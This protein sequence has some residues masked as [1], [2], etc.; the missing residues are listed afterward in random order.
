MADRYIDPD[1][2]RARAQ[3][4][5]GH[6]KDVATNHKRVYPKS[7]D[8]V[9]VFSGPGDYFRPLKPE[10]NEQPYQR[11]RDQD[12]IRA[13]VA[14]VR[15]VTANRL[16]KPVNQVT[17]DDVLNHGPFMVYNGQ[18]SENTAFR[19]ATRGEDSKI[20]I[21]KVIV[22]DEVRQPDRVIPIVHTA[23]QY[24]S[25][26][27]EVANPFS[28]IHDIR[29][30]AL[31]AHIPDFARHPYYAEHFSQIYEARGVQRLAFWAYGVKSRQGSTD[32]K[33]NLSSTEPEHLASEL[34]ALVRYAKGGYL[35][36]T[37]VH[38]FT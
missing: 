7:I 24:E 34:Y 30:V 38:L 2:L 26:L 20:P 19:L 23:H 1:G 17:K 37:P 5:I 22:I 28:P 12:R 16:E 4:I 21:E 29:E 10:R 14:V 18:P 31:V 11:W 9:L 27:Q 35:S 13:G 15:N 25:F 6:L 8:A 32:P 3:E 33:L 36:T